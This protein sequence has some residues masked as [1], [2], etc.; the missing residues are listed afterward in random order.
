MV[1]VALYPP[2]DRSEL[3]V[4]ANFT[5]FKASRDEA[6]AALQPLHDSRPRGAAAEVFCQDTSL[7]QE[8]GAQATANPQGHRYCSDNAYVGNDEDVAA[9]LEAAFTTL[10]TRKS[11]ALYFSM[12]PTS[13]R[14]RYRD[15]AGDGGMALSMQS[16]HY[17]A[18]YAVWDDAGEDEAC[19]AWV[20]DA[21][22]RVERHAVGS[23][24]GDA[25]FQ[26]RR[27]RF[28]ADD[29]ARRLMA[30][31]RRRWDPDGTICGF[32]DEGDQ[33]G[34]AGLRNEFE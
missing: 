11:T 19:A 8:Y 23:Y 25:D 12:S 10:P 2:P 32:L 1:A 31:V 14:A 33:S 7:T 20:H 9:V 3:C 16:D 27:T 4:L 5:T 28:W 21:M 34:A 24:L 30:A 17:F 18:L 13:R 29:N 6:Q 26:R 22:G 15:N